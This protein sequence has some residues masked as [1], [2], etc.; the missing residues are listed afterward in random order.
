MGNLLAMDALLE[1]RAGAGDRE[2]QRALGC[3]YEHAGRHDLARGW[4]ARAAQTGDAVA[5][6]LLA[7]NLLTETPIAAAD[8]IGM[9][10]SAAERGD[11]EALTLCAAVAAQDRDLASNWLV[12]RDYLVRAAEHG[13][14]DA[15]GQLRVLAGDAACT[16]PM[17][18]ARKIDFARWLAPAP[19]R[20]VHETPRIL[21][22]E[23]FAQAAECDWLIARGRGRLK[24]SEIY[25]PASGRGLRAGEIRSNSAAAFNIAQ[26]DVVLAL[27]RERIARAVGIATG[28]LEPAMLLHYATGEQFAPH[29]DFIDPE[30]P[31]FAEGIA[32]SGQR[33]ATFL[34]YLSDAHEGGETEFVDLGWRHRGAKGDALIFWNVGPDGLPDRRTLHAG[35]AP[36]HGEKWLLSQWIRGQ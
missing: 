7:V 6:R 28:G 11:A 1:R 5:L 34:L 25:D 33:V 19:S 32:R 24:P 36:T 13:S 29:Y 12:A 30:V 18:L 20:G 35:L 21:I 2:A 23:G 10:R 17:A 16:S 14:Q 26:S 27:L 9:L 31:G 4:F 22:A 3:R 8:G 15:I